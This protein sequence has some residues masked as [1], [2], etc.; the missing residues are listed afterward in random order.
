MSALDD[1]DCAILRLLAT[2]AGASAAEVGRAVGLTQPAAW[3]RIRRLT[4]EGILRGR[5]VVV[6]AAMRPRRGSPVAEH[7]AS[8]AARVKKS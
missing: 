6:D 1:T 7:F 8:A 2:G 5:R 3:R 4:E